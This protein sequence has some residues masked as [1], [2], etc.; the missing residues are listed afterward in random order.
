MKIHS[1]KKH[2]ALNYY[3]KIVRDVVK[4]KFGNLYYADLFCGD[5]E[6][7]VKEYGKE[8]NPSLIDAVLKPA[9]EGKLSVI[10]FLNDKEPS[11][12]EKMKSKT[13]DYAGFIA[14]YG[15]E[16]ANEYYKTVLARA[17]RGRF[18]IF[19]LDPYNH[20]EL[21]WETIR[22][23]SE[24]SNT[25]GG[26]TYR[27]EIIINFMTHSM[28][29]SW[30]AKSYDSITAALGTDKWIDLIKTNKDRN[31]PRPILSALLTTFV[32]QLKSLGYSVP[33]PIPITETS[34][35]NTVYYLIWATNE[36][37]YEIIEKR[38][39][40]YLRERVD[41]LQEANVTESL[42]QKDKKKGIKHLD[43][44]WCPSS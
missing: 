43:K 42:R 23:I 34:R 33:T 38:V 28:L 2:L 25:Y 29:N 36:H 44:F 13:K 30:R 18:I 10:C 39:M 31:V 6:C 19:F 27:P 11:C 37:G 35:G 14:D 16:D 4:V 12:I 3:F 26:K 20:T 1:N 40:R 41:E 8:W 24:H 15:N 9:K 7:I 32:E 21:K 17:P 5:G 22:K